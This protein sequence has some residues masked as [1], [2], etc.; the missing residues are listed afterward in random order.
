VEA[1]AIYA[2]ETWEDDDDI[3]AIP[4]TPEQAIRI[5]GFK[6]LLV[7]GSNRDDECAKAVN[8]VGDLLSG[9]WGAR[10]CRKLEPHEIGIMYPMLRNANKG[11]FDRFL[12]NLTDIAPTVWLSD[13]ENREARTLIHDQ[14]IKV[15][16]IH[17]AKGLQYPAVILIWSDELPNRQNDSDLEKDKKLMYVALTRPEDYL[18]VTYSGPS[19]F[20]ADLAGSETME[21]YR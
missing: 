15:Q 4:V 2:S 12:R 7:K 17:S 9:K 21:L 6:P 13:P 11:V 5:P 3:N 1:A 18:A 19:P 14:G 16:T 10:E 8:L 20:V